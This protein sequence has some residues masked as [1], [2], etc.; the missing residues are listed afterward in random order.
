MRL[1]FPSN[2]KTTLALFSSDA[3]EER[4]HLFIVPPA[5]PLQLFHRGQD[6]LWNS[7]VQACS[8]IQERL[9]LFFTGGSKLLGRDISLVKLQH[10][11]LLFFFSQGI[12]DCKID[13]VTVKKHLVI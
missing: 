13:A 2:L 1:I 12:F 4:E 3:Q 9:Q 6:K 10:D 11:Y 8:E 5:I 7:Q